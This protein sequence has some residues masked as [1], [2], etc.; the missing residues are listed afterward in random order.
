LVIL[1]PELRVVT[2]NRSFYD[3]FRVSREETERQSFFDIGNRQWNIPLLRTLLEEILPR[4]RAVEHFEV[5]H[6][7]AAIGRRTMLLNAR[8]VRSA[9]GQPALVLLAI[10]DVTDVKS[11]ERER[12]ARAAAEATTAAKDQVLAVLTHELRTP[13]TAMPG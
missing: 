4:D 9:T 5:E 2:A 3:T 7:F 12:A 13:L 10:E 1:D 6:D 8:R 11:I